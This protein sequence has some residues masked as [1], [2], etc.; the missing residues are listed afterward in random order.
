MGK[1][2][3]DLRNEH[4]TILHVVKI[5]DKVIS[6]ENSREINTNLQFGNEL[7]KFL[8]IFVDKCHHG[9]EENYLFGELVKTG[10]RNEGGPIGLMLAEHKLGREY[11][12]LMNKYLELK[13]SAKFNATAAKYSDLLKSHIQKENNI[14]FITADQIL[15]D[16]KQNELFDKFEQHEENVIG[17]GVHEE[18]HSMI[19][20]WAEQFGVK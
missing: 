19:H 10:V 5:I 6:I 7:V 15:N 20:R 8:K 17:S 14:L 4:G 13:D 12:G 16:A 2:T 9:K 11:V 1:A 18:L 3:Q